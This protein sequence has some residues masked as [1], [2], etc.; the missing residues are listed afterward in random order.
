MSK[1]GKF[2][3]GDKGIWLAVIV[4]TGFSLLAVYSSTG[5]LA[6]KKQHGNT[7]YYLLRHFSLLS[8]GFVIMYVMHK[9]PV[10]SLKKLSKYFLYGIIP[11]LLYTL[12]KGASLN[13]ASRWLVVPIVKLSIQT[14][15]IAKLALIMFIA[16][17]ISNHQDDLKDLK[18]G[19]LPILGW[20]VLVVGLIFPANFSTAAMIFMIAM[21]MLFIGRFNILHLLSVAGVGLVFLVVLYL[22]APQLSHLGR[23]G[24]WANRVERFI[25]SDD[26]DED[27]N[28]Q[29]ERSQIAIVNSGLI[30]KGPGKS[31]QRNFLPHPYSDFIFAI[32]VEEYG[33]FGA[34]AIIIAYLT[35]FYRTG[36]I[37]TK[38]TSI[39]ASYL[40]LGLGLA[41]TTQA[42]INMGVATG[43]F[44][45]TGQTLPLVSM[46]GSSI[47]FTCV[48]LGILLSISRD[49]KKETSAN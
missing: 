11:I 13:E 37:V 2:F 44:P 41:L 35:I 3:G 47:L 7:T 34:F 10:L 31:E 43:I 6:Y 16:R 33:L 36:V 38:S 32:I 40:A 19:F 1:L 29:A 20:I 12:V 8:F 9:I 15:D 25:S 17:Y 30:G 4:L 45:V 23:V 39:F 46:G 48:S 22:M 24:T 49:F 27:A 18:K 26:V 14:S 5:T 21:M 28:F 42:F